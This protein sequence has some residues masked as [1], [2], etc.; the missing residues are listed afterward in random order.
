[1]FV[2]TDK[3]CNAIVGLV[4][5]LSS[6]LKGIDTAEFADLM[7]GYG[8]LWFGYFAPILIFAEFM[9]GVLLLFDVRPRIT[10]VVT[11]IFLVAVSAV[12]LYGV[13]AKGIT[14]CGCFG[15]LTWLKSKPWLTFLRNG[16]LLSLLL[17][18]LVKPQQ[19]ANLTMPTIA[20]LAVT[21]IAVMFMCGYSI[22]GAKCLQKQDT[23]EPIPLSSSPLSALVSCNADST[24]LVFA[25]FYSCPY[26]Q[27]SI[28]NVNQYTDMKAVDRVIGIAVADSAARARFERIFHYNFEIRE[29]DAV[30]MLS[31]T[32]TLPSTWL[33][34][35]DSI[36][37]HNTGLVV[38]P[39]L[40]MP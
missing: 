33:I 6:V 29:T 8:T 36:V 14:D 24:Y 19:G 4:F 12:Y 28:G 2:K 11:T 3:I 26:C 5:L 31:L 21:G 39:A 30:R 7:S 32:H 15:P 9:L 10:A 25:F 13:A 22:H 23:F 18:S 34:Q 20:F 17:P 16:V 1:M 27:N 37:S 38:S 35:H 40:F